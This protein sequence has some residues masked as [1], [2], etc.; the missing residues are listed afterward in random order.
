MDEEV[1]VT[2]KTPDSV[3]NPDSM[4]QNDSMQTKQTTDDMAGN[5]KE[6]IKRMFL[7]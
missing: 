5:Q 6:A 7:I 3:I 1:R 4:S 2:V